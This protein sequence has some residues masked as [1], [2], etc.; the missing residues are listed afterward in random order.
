MAVA[1]GFAPAYVVR[2]KVGPLPTT[3]LELLLLLGIVVGFAALRGRL[4]WRNPYTLPGIVLLAGA[5]IG[6]LVSP[7][8]TGALGE[9]RAFFVEPMAAGLVIA[10]LAGSES[11]RRL[12]LLGLAASGLA[13]ALV[14][15]GDDAPRILAGQFNLASPPVAIYQNANQLALYLVPL[16]AVAMAMLLFGPRRAERSGA[17]VFLA[18][19][20]PAVLLSYSR[21]GIAALVVALLV[22]AALHPRRARIAL[23]L[24]AV[25][26]AGVALVPGIR[27]RVLFEFDPSSP[28]NTVNSRLD[29]WRGTLRML[30]HRPLQGA[31]LR[32]FDARVAPYY[33]DPFRV[34]FPHDIVLNFWSDTGLLGLLGFAWLSLAALV[35]AGRDLAGG[36]GALALNAGVVGFIVAV[37]VHGAVDVPYFKND[38]ALAFWAVLGLHAGALRSPAP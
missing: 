31:G 24:A 16:D 7:D 10:G 6:V 18:V 26:A 34:A 28:N 35:A 14:N 36:A 33:R 38:L 9:W 27:R 20:V 2:F 29:L 32:G 19:T 8:R 17:A 22:V 23:P 37:W 12:L 4:P 30:K 3:L 15:L 13:A 1:L 21:G 5:T 11:R 25:L